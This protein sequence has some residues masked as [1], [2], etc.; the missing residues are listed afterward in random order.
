MDRKIYKKVSYKLLFILIIVLFQSCIFNLKPPK[1]ILKYPENLNNLPLPVELYWELENDVKLKDITY[2]VKYG[3]NKYILDKEIKTSKNYIKIENLLPETT[4]YLQIISVKGNQTNESEIYEFKTTDIPK[5]VFENNESLIYKKD[6]LLSWNAIDQD[7]IKKYE[8]YMSKSNDFNE[9]EFLY[10]GPNNSYPIKDLK[11]GETYYFKVIAYDKFDMTGEKTIKITVGDFKFYNF[12]PSNM[13]KSV[14][15]NNVKL[16][17]DY[18]GESNSFTLIFSPNKDLSDDSNNYVK[19]KISNREYLLKPLPAGTTF[20]WKIID[21]INDIESPVQTFTTS[22]IPE[23]KITYP[24]K[25]KETENYPVGI[26]RDPKI[27]WESTDIDNDELTFYIKLKEVNENDDPILVNFSR[28]LLVDDSTK[29]TYYNVNGLGKGKFYALKIIAN[30]GKGNEDFDI[31]KFKTNIEPEKPN[32][33][34]P[35][36]LIDI[37]TQIATLTWKCYDPDNELKFKVYLGESKSELSLKGET[38]NYYYEIK[39]LKYGTEYFWQIEAIDTNNATSISDIATFMTNKKPILN[40]INPTINATN[41]SLKTKL[42]WDFVD[43]N[44]SYYKLYFS[45]YNE[46]LSLIATLTENKYEIDT[47]PE[48]KYQWEVIAFDTYNAS[49]TSGINYFETTNR[50]S[51]ELLSPDG[52]NVSLKPVFSW[53]GTDSDNDDLNYKFYLYLSNEL[54]DEISTQSTTINYSDFLKTD[55]EYSWK[56][57]VEDSNFATNVSE[58]LSFKTTQEPTITLIYPLSEENLGANINLTW[59]AT[60]IDNDEIYY[61]IYLNDTK[62][63]T[64]SSKEYSLDNLSPSTLYTWKVIAFD[65]NL[66]SNTSIE[67]TF[68]TANSLL[69]KPNITN[70]YGYDESGNLT[71][72][73]T[74]NEKKYPNIFKIIWKSSNEAVYYD[75]YKIKNDVESV[76]ATNVIN[77]ST[78][79]NIPDGGSIKLY[80]KAFDNN[81][82]CLNGDEITLNI[83]QPPV[84]LDYSPRDNETNISLYPTIIWKAEDYDSQTFTIRVF[85][86]KNEDELEEEYIPNAQSEGEY[87]I[88]TELQPG[89][90]YYWKLKLEDEV[91]GITETDFRE[92]TTTHR[93][94]I[95]SINLSDNATNVKLNFKLNWEGYDED[96]D[97]LSYTIKLNGDTLKDN[98]VNNE[99]TLNLE[100]DNNYILELIAKDD[101]DSQNSTI[102][103]FSTTKPPIIFNMNVDDPKHFK[104]G[105]KIYWE[106]SDPNDD[107]LYYEIYIGNSENSLSKIATTEENYYPLNNLSE[108][109][110]YYWKIIAFDSKGA[111]AESEIK[112]FKTNTSPEFINNIYPENN[113]I[114]IEKN[115]TLS[116]EATDIEKDKIKYD[117]YFGENKDNLIIKAEDY[118]ISYYNLSNLE[119]GKTYYWKVI[120][121]DDFGGESESKIFSFTTN[122]LPTISKFNYELYNGLESKVIWNAI[123]PEGHIIKFDLLKSLDESNY[124]TILY[125]TSATNIY[126]ERLSPATNYY[127]KI[128]AIDE[129]NDFAESTITFKTDS[130]DTNIF[131]IERGDNSKENKVIDLIENVDTNEFVFVEKEDSIYYLTKIDNTGTETTI[132]SSATINFE[133]YFIEKYNSNILLLGISAGKIVFDEYGSNLTPIVSTPTSVDSSLLKDYIKISDNEYILL[134]EDAG[135]NYIWKVNISNGSKESEKSFDGMDLYSIIKIRDE[136]DKEKYILSGEKDGEG[137]IVKIDEKFNIEDEKTF[138]DIDRVAKLKNIGN[139]FLSIGFINNDLVIKEFSYRLNELYK[140]VYENDYDN[141]FVDIISTDNGYLIVLNNNDGD[142]EILELDENINLIEKHYFGREEEDKALGMIKTSDNGYIIFGQTKF[143]DQTNGNS[144]IIKVDSKLKGWSTPEKWRKK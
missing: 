140:P 32:N 33:L 71:K 52:S 37:P 111:F 112:S 106:A 99:Y 68:M 66:A 44:T 48:T 26:S 24:I 43:N 31:V 116:W 115:I 28:D 86:G 88:K 120:A 135:N 38:S 51:V 56:V 1:P 137:Y 75:V 118:E 55:N 11:I 72:E 36:N 92:F 143:T 121:K 57:V 54:I 27:T 18:S 119:N 125:N 20:Y 129:K 74:L 21:D 105:D 60:D 114:G 62:I 127:L 93:P 91:G 84:L 103:N 17:F 85:F 82:F 46:P 29:N 76:I 117:I 61:E 142:I 90:K 39:D 5:V 58:L 132:N 9:S 80:V 41:I 40:N 35:K 70:I 131:T 139:T 81:G 100:A 113:S 109:E 4:Y 6:I 67:A 128:R 10:E 14:P 45:K 77:N 25:N 42:E 96:S 122:L 89:Q 65:S 134:G 108:G 16:S 49:G 22:Y 124:S 123:D 138:S 130:V 101:K 136:D 63:A 126:L 94:E 3:T 13:A 78:I 50:P 144:Y 2:I 79:V 19:E 87:T 30:D 133:P 12:Q 23:I 107:E 34:S 102:I 8:L 95:N 73:Y 53:K 104:N 59:E 110:T 97:N 98:L 47:L 69:N 64:S 83:N 7:G 15:L 141:S